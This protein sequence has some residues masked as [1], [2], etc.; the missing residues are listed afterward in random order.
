LRVVYN[1]HSKHLAAALFYHDAFMK[2]PLIK[3]NDFENYQD[4]N[5]GLFMTYPKDLEELKKAKTQNPDLITAIVDPRG[6]M[7]E[8]YI[9]YTDFFVVDSIEMKDFFAKYSKPIFTYY[10]YPDVPLISKRHIKKEKIIIGYHGN[11]VHL[12]AMYPEITMALELLAEKYDIELWVMYN[13]DRLGKWDIGVPSN[14]FV[15]HIQWNISAYQ[16]YL[17]HVDIGLAPACMPIKRSARKKSIV[18]KFFLDNEDDY[19]IKF[20]MPSNP[21]RII[22][23]A[24]LGIPV[25]ADFL[26]SNLQF[27]RDGENGFLA[28]STGGWYHAIDKLVASHRLRQEFS[29]NMMMVYNKYFDVEIQ[30]NNLHEFLN[31][32]KIEKSEV[33]M[34]NKT[35]CIEDFKFNNAFVYEKIKKIKGII[36]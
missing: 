15:K 11:K 21:G 6:S 34:K 20:K 28:K 29:D 26:P 19:L 35:R 17:A 36:F 7:I 25:V 16:D 22:V 32:M 30:N 14:M 3:I 33:I 8:S 31:Q 13:I 10:E 2:D 4:Y 23:F 9:K 5:I 18:S 24:M 1:T 27:I 12:T